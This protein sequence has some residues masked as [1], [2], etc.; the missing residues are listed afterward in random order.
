M[1][2]GSESHPSSDRTS[3]KSEWFRI[4][5]IRLAAA[6][7]DVN[8][9]VS[10]T[11]PKCSDS[12]TVSPMTETSSTARPALDSWILE[13]SILIIASDLDGEDLIS[14]VLSGCDELFTSKGVASEW[15]WSTEVCAWAVGR[16]N[17][18]DGRETTGGHWGWIELA[19]C[20]W[21]SKYSSIC[22]SVTPWISSRDRRE[23]FSA[24]TFLPAFWT[25]CVAATP[26]RS[27]DLNCCSSCWVYSLRRVR[28]RRWFS[29]NRAD[30]ASPF[31]ILT[32]F[33]PLIPVLGNGN[34]S[35]EDTDLGVLWNS[36]KSE[37]MVKLKLNSV[38]TFSHSS[39]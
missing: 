28:E 24:A 30:D 39:N 27:N 2:F 26:S 10:W 25:S 9:P 3:P 33:Y 37:D 4:L 34:A 32:A 7:H 22:I 5:S 35:S 19:V 31:F 36:W 20:L 13:A 15:W 21:D 16:C 8:W 14:W 11:P 12:G 38:A 29:R 23:T 17:F 1:Q 6:T 18:A